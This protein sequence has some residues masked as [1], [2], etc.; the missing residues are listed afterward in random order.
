MN[1]SIVYEGHN[2]CN[3]S[4]ENKTNTQLN[5]NSKYYVPIKVY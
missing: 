3:R 4:S 2:I 1:Y 5:V